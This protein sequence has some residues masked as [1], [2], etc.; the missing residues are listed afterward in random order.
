MGVF[1]IGLGVLYLAYIM[2]SRDKKSIYF[3]NVV[4]IEGKEQE[5]LSLQLS[6]SIL[7]GIL[8][9]VAGLVYFQYDL[10]TFYFTTVPLIFHLNNFIAKLVGHRK[11]YLEDI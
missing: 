8:L 5:Y 10:P 2:V 3:K 6:V 1:L 11:G 7:N 9:I 4:I